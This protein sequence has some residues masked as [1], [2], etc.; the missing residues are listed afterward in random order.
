MQHNTRSHRPLQE[1]SNCSLAT[2][3][4]SFLLLKEGDMCRSFMCASRPLRLTVNSVLCDLPKT[5]Y[6]QRLK[7]GS[8]FSTSFWLLVNNV[9]HWR[10]GT[11]ILPPSITLE[12]DVYRVVEPFSPALRPVTCVIIGLIDGQSQ[13]QK[14]SW[15]KSTQLSERM[16][17]GKWNRLQSRTPQLKQK[18]A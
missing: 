12:P 6:C 18:R 1:N 14:C 15:K 8:P 9:S 2:F 17:R 7:M 13:Q 3:N 5:C 4:K 16:Y 10:N 11:V